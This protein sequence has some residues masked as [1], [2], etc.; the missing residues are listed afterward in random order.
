MP[1]SAEHS[2]VILAYKESPYLEECILSVVNQRAPSA[3]VLATSTPNTH[4]QTLAEK[5]GLKVVVRTDTRRGI[6]VDFNFALEAAGDARFVTICHQDDVYDDGYFLQVRE[7][8]QDDTLLVFTDYAEIR[9]AEVVADNRLLRVKRT[10]LSPL[11]AKRFWGSRFIRRRVLSLGSAICCPSVTC[12][13]AFVQPGIFDES[14]ETNMDWDAWARLSSRKGKYVYLANKPLM[15]HRIHEGSAT[16]AVLAAEKRAQEDLAV[17]KLFWPTW[18][19]RIILRFYRS[20][21]ASNTVIQKAN[22]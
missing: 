2:F 17:F 15:Y 8:L 7:H 18:I 16:T 20:A 13:A 9:G 22:D 6:A 10:M 12:N 1:S 19:A 21:E 5:Y 4:I 3:V 11:K 14:F